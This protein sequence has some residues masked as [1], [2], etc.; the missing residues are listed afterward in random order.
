M[1]LYSGMSPA[2]IRE[3]TR[4]Q[5]AELLRQAF[6]NYFRYNPPP[7][8]VNSWRNSLRAMKDVMEM[9]G[10]DDH[11]V[12]LEYQ[13]PLSSRRIDCIVC[14][15]DAAGIDRAVLVELKQWD[16][17]Q[18]AG[19]EKLVT[20]WVGGGHRELLHPSVQVGQYRQYLEDTHTAFHEGANPIKL[21]SCCYLHNYLPSADDPIL[22]SK[23]EDVLA[24]NPLFDADGAERLT[25]YL[26]ERLEQGH[27]EPVLQRIEASKYRP[28]RKLMEHVSTTI[29]ARSP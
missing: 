2:F 15:R 27:G 20:S 1:R 13:L 3:T 21:A 5:I 29:R 4:N 23:F 17:C 16:R 7:A 22:S 12:L 8:E 19:P 9:S 24:D 10:F 26:R 28:S 14:G 6:F 18:P 11:G 25:T